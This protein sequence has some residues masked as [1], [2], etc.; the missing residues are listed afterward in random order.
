MKPENKILGIPAGYRRMENSERRPPSKAKFLGPADSNETL[1]V[2]ITLRCRHDGPPL[3]DVNSFASTP[4][5]ERPHMKK[6]EF[7]AKYGAALDDILKVVEFAKAK[8]LKVIESNAVTAYSR[9][10]RDGSPNE[11]GIWGQVRTLST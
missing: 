9:S 11:R 1:S 2:T 7:K 4:P 10:F 3:P 5:S 8:G 6:D